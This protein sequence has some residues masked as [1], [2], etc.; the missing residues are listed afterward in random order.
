MGTPT[1]GQA[2]SDADRTPFLQSALGWALIVFLVLSAIASLG[3]GYYVFSRIN[4]IADTAGDIMTSGDLSARLSIDSTWDDLSRLSV[5][6]NRMLEEI[7]VLVDSVQV[8]LRQH[9]A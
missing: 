4:R 9:R 2:G 5:V 6:L 8:G 7:E 3:I 1:V